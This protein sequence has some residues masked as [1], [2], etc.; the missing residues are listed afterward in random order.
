MRLTSVLSIRSTA[1]PSSTTLSTEQPALPAAAFPALPA[2][3]MPAAAMPAAAFPALPKVKG[4]L[5][6][7]EE[8]PALSRLNE[9]GRGA[10]DLLPASMAGLGLCCVQT[11]LGYVGGRIEGVREGGVR[12]MVG[13][14]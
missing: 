8:A 11:Y 4:G 13:L 3:A 1:A 10:A 7:D 9:K 2:A 12:V 6:D 5:A 14:W